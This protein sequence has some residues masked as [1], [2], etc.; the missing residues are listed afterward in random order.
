MWYIIDSESVSLM[1]KASSSQAGTKAFVPEGR[2]AMVADILLGIVGGIIA[3]AIC[4][5][6]K[7]LWHFKH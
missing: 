1:E 2:S 7:T 4:G 6:A 5:G 3:N